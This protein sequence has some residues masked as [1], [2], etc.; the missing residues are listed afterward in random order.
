MEDPLQTYANDSPCRR[1]R[2]LVRG[3]LYEVP[4]RLR[5]RRFELRPEQDGRGGHRERLLRLLL[6]KP[7]RHG[8]REYP[9]LRAAFGPQP[10]LGLA[11]QPDQPCAGT[12]CDTI[13]RRA[14]DAS[15]HRHAGGEY[16]Q[17]HLHVGGQRDHPAGARPYAGAHAQGLHRPQVS[18]YELRGDRP[19]LPPLAGTG[20]VGH[21]FG[22]AATACGAQRL[23]AACRPAHAAALI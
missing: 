2:L 13:R 22:V 1:K 8:R 4:C 11:P 20:A 3:A 23:R 19:S 17:H 18:G 12:L 6:G 7:Q 10:V 21:P 15:E 5:K 16:A 14:P 9:G